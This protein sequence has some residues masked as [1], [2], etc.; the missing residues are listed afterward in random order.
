MGKVHL[1]QTG[2]YLGKYVVSGHKD[3]MQ[4][5][6][7]APSSVLRNAKVVHLVQTSQ[8]NRIKVVSLLPLYLSPIPP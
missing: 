3:V 4:T 2:V 8:P 1:E 7:Q 6:S 5:T